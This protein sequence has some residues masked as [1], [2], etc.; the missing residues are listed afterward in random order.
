MEFLPITRETTRRYGLIAAELRR[1]G[2]AIPTNDAW[3]ASHALEHSAE[4]LTAD[5]HF[6]EISGLVHSGWS[7]R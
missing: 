7:R 6:A 5:S 3:I 4:L 1:Q 2:R